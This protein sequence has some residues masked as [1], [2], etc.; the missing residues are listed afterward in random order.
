MATYKDMICY[1]DTP[2]NVKDHFTIK[3][4]DIFVSWKLNLPEPK[5]E[6]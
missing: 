1:W 6:D 5:I 3:F 2:I 4:G